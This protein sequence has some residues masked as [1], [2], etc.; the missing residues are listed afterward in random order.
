MPDNKPMTPEEFSQHIYDVSTKTAREGRFVQYE[1]IKSIRAYTESIRREGHDSGAIWMLNAICASLCAY[2]Y[3]G[4][5][6][7]IMK[8]VEN[9]RR[10]AKL[11]E[12]IESCPECRESYP[13]GREKFL[14]KITIDTPPAAAEAVCPRCEGERVIMVKEAGAGYADDLAEYE[15]CPDCHG[16]GKAVSK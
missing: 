9:I 14:R 11:E 5:D 15:P 12:H 2:P 6:I 10:E 13:C 1:W 7:E 4:G 3:G 8:A 16:T